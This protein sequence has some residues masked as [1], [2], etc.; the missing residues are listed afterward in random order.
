MNFNRMC[1]TH[2]K[3]KKKNEANIEREQKKQNQM[4]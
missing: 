2:L 4:Q 3:K 1:D